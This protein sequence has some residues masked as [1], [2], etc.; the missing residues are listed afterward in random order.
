MSNT[1]F[2]YALVLAY[3]LF[4]APLDVFAQGCSDAGFCTL[5]NLQLKPITRVNSMGNSTADTPL[6]RHQIAIGTSVGV[7]DNAVLSITPSLQYE[8]RFSNTWQIQAKG[9][10]NYADGNLGSAFGLGDV[11]VS[12]IYNFTPRKAWQWSVSAGAK[13]ALNNANLQDGGAALPMS[14]QSSLGTNDWIIGLSTHNKHW[15]FAAGWQQTLTGSNKNEYLP[16]LWWEEERIYPPSRH[17]TRRADVLLRAAYKFDIGQSIS[18]NVG[19]LG[20]YHV[21]NDKYDSLNLPTRL[22]IEGS[23]G[24]TFNTTAGIWYH[25]NPKF[26]IGVVGGMPLL[27][28]DIRPDGLTRR[29]VFSPEITLQF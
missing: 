23:A 8:Y 26:S 1:N 14:Y 28:R 12:G 19:A 6:L 3:C 25:I 29:F 4:R 24:L 9:T 7:G 20:I 5:G 22:P 27:V 11:F 16:T 21:G 18:I 10:V 17:L 13:F 15:Q 2:F